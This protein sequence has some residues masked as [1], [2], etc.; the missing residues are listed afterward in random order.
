[1]RY[2]TSTTSLL[3]DP[4][5]Q[6]LLVSA[7]YRLY[8][9]LCNEL[10]RIGCEAIHVSPRK[11]ILVTK[12]KN[13]AEAI[14]YVDFI[15]KTLRKKEL[16]QAIDFKFTAAWETLLWHNQNN[17]GGIQVQN[18]IIREIMGMEDEDDDVE[19]GEEEDEMVM[20]FEWAEHLPTEAGMRA[21]FTQVILALQPLFNPFLADRGL[22]QG[23]PRAGEKRQRRGSPGRVRR[24]NHDGR[25]LRPPP[26]SDAEDSQ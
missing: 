21:S 8:K 4:A 17:Y 20:K 18:S 22:H 7:V 5:I 15:E 11:L 2:I 9:L 25:I 13:I 16:F 12:K 14:G 19:E 3:F 26:R 10:K 6:E 1:M 23:P 24:R